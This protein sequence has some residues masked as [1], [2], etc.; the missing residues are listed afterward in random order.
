MEAVLTNILG[1]LQDP[2]YKG[3]LVTGLTW[4]FKVKPEIKTALPLVSLAVNVVLELV[5]AAAE[6][7]VGPV[8][9]AAF[10]VAAV[11]EKPAGFNPVLDILLPQLI[12]DG[13]YNWPRKA[14]A[15][16]KARLGVR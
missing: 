4:L 5:S 1:F 13:A 6:A 7:A 11:M 10:S 9:P 15:W 3:L 14:W 16:L 8:A 12:A 2:L